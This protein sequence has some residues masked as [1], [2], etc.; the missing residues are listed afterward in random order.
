[1]SSRWPAGVISKNPVV[2]AGP[3]QNNAA[4]GMWRMD[5]V[6]YWRKQGMWPTP[7]VVP[8]PYFNNVT[9]L[10]STTAL[11]NVSNRLFVDNSEMFN[12]VWPGGANYGGSGLVAQGLVTPY[13]PTFSN[14]FDGDNDWIDVTATS[15]QFS[16]DVPYTV[17]MWI[18]TVPGGSFGQIYYSGPNF[19]LGTDSGK[20]AILNGSTVI[21]AGTAEPIVGVWMHIA[22]VYNGSTVTL[23]VNGV[24]QGSAAGGGG[25][26]SGNVR[27]GR[28][29]LTAGG[30]FKG[31]MSN[32]RV[33][34]GTAL[35]TSNFTPP[36]TPLTVVSGTSL[37]TCTGNR[38]LD[39]SPNKLT[40]TRTGSVS[41]AN[42]NPFAVKYPGLI[43]TY[44]Q[45]AASAWSGYFAGEWH[46]WISAPTDTAFAFGTGDFCMEAWVLCQDR[47]SYRSVMTIVGGISIIIFGGAT[48]LVLD[49]TSGTTLLADTSVFPLNQWIHVAC[50][51][52][53]GTMR[54]FINGALKASATVTTSFASTGATYIASWDGFNYRWVGSIS[55]A[56]I[57]KGSAVYTSAF[58]PPTAPLTAI[59]GTSL[60]TCQNSTFIDNS[61]NNFPITTSGVSTTTGQNPFVPSGY[62]GLAG[63][64]DQGATIPQT[65]A[66]DLGS[67]DFTVE[68]WV[69][70]QTTGG[71][72]TKRRTDTALTGSWAFS[73]GANGYFT[74]L[75]VGWAS[76]YTS[77]GYI[78]IG[79]W[80]HLAVSRS[81]TN[82]SMY[83][84]GVRVYNTTDNYNYTCSTYT[85][86]KLWGNSGGNYPA[87]G[88]L[89][90]GFVGHV[91]NLRIVQGA[92]VYNPASATLT[93]PTSP[94]TA[95]PGTSL[96]TCQDVNLKDNSANNLTVSSYNGGNQVQFSPFDTYPTISGYGSSVYVNGDGTSFGPRM[97][98]SIL[99]HNNLYSD[100]T[101]EFWVYPTQSYAGADK[102]L[103]SAYSGASTGWH[104][105]ITSAG[106]MYFGLP[107]NPKPI[108]STSTPP[109]GVWS[110]I[111][112]TRSG[113][114]LRMF[115]NGTLLTS[116]TYDT[117]LTS[118]N[119]IMFVGSLT[120]SDYS[121]AGY[122]S[123]VRL[124]YTALYTSAFT[125]PTAPLSASQ[126][127][128]A[129]VSG[130]GARVYDAAGN[131]PMQL[132]GDAKVSTTVSKFGGASL[133]FDGTGDR[134]LT[135]V[136]ELMNL[137]NG[138]FTVEAWVYSNTIAAGNAA[139]ATRSSS[140]NIATGADLQWSIYRSGSTMFVRAYQGTTD[141]SI[142][143]GTIAANTWYHVAI[144]RSGT[145][146]RGFLN[147]VLAGTTR[148]ITG[149]LNNNTG[150]FGVI[151]GGITVSS[152]N[153]YWN[154][155][156]DDLRITK[157][158]ARYTATF[159]PPTEPFPPY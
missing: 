61:P 92:A 99:N 73:T 29:A 58:T 50:S 106:V 28:Y 120:G 118:S 70:R 100:F 37:L 83:V 144:T 112:V 121:F 81:G 159:T 158:I 136:D 137:A 143:V 71:I 133:A 14:Y 107:P 65:T 56:R 123:D 69:N 157:G 125:P 52:E 42:V 30:G 95:I 151:M 4:P 32:V 105:G 117:Q 54:L 103:V 15:S 1:M 51:R 62:W 91:S 80:T 27:L 19:S 147:G 44:G 124:S 31:Y 109:V 77:T 64:A 122:F 89:G 145:T 41:V 82:L 128:R 20:I 13:G 141:F 119:T 6:A 78:P 146:V 132:L 93:V 38:F 111:A 94:L 5:E 36:T 35:Y 98:S 87:G 40:C 86:I 25:A 46:D 76:T 101:I 17:E 155:Y 68:C 129:L 23:Y 96:L 127:T 130:D 135:P 53:S 39:F 153:E 149:A 55:N 114:T 60:L 22:M 34:K 10:L 8:D 148:T 150:W 142:N 18:N 79:K 116:T 85:I 139:V 131:N 88:A 49:R 115:L 2:P 16:Q 154:G 74:F 108:T 138:D 152:V 63:Y 97:N 11:K 12:P 26:Y 84:D 90:D 57:V 72:V 21:V 9:L 48:M 67:G 140:G 3:A 66:T 45:T 134:V 24:S 7:G 126:Y 156:I 47:S 104:I 43:S 75:G 110:H 113:S 102:V 33:V 59:S